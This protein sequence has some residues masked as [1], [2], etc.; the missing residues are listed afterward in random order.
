MKKFYKSVV[1]AELDA[2]KAL[3]RL[4]FLKPKIS[5]QRISNALSK[6][7]TGTQLNGFLFGGLSKRS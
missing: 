1:K 7:E 2:R 6:T 3:S 4:T 5:V